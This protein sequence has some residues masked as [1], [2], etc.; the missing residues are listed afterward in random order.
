MND[1]DWLAERFEANR[2]HLRGVAFRM[3]GSVTEADDAVQEAWIRLS[4][5][6]TQA[7]GVSGRSRRWRRCCHINAGWRVN[8]MTRPMAGT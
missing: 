7:G 1:Q 4:R 5:T 8:D 6:D 2:S 3:L